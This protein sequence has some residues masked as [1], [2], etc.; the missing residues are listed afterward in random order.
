MLYLMFCPAHSNFSGSV[1]F[2]LSM[3]ITPRGPTGVDDPF[4]WRR[5]L[6]PLQDE[7]I[8][9]APPFPPTPVLKDTIEVQ[10]STVG[11]P[12]GILYFNVSWEAPTYPNGNLELY[13]LCLGQEVVNGQENCTSQPVRVCIT[14]SIVNPN[15][16]PLEK[17]NLGLPFKDIKYALER[18]THGVFLQVLLSLCLHL[19]LRFI[20]H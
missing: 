6:V 9:E 19:T 12:L 17:N 2:L 18:N 11:Q 7:C 1:R 16:S 5:P 10:S 13:E 14:P 20:V 15:C 3:Q 8:I 4:F